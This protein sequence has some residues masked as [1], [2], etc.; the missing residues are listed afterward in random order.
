MALAA[1]EIWANGNPPPI[2]IEDA[3]NKAGDDVGQGLLCNAPVNV[4]GLNWALH[5][6]SACLYGELNSVSDAAG[7]IYN[8]DNPVNISDAVCA[9]AEQKA[10]QIATQLAT[11]IATDIATQIACQTFS[12]R[13]SGGRVPLHGLQQNALSFTVPPD[14]MW[15]VN[16]DYNG[17][18]A[19]PVVDGNNPQNIFLDD[20]HNASSGGDSVT[21]AGGTTITIEQTS[22]V[23]GYVT[24]FAMRI[25]CAN[26]AAPVAAAD[27]T[28][29]DCANDFPVSITGWPADVTLSAN[30]TDVPLNVSFTDDGGGMGTLASTGAVQNGTLTITGTDPVGAT[31]TQNIG[32]NC[33]SG[34]G[35]GSTSFSAPNDMTFNNCT[36]AFP[37]SIT[38]WPSTATISANGTDTAL[39]FSFTD[40]GNGTGSLNFAGSFNNGTVILTGTDNGYSDSQN[41]VIDCSQPPTS[42]GCT[43]QNNF[44]ADAINL[45]ISGGFADPDGDALTYTATGL[46]FGLSLHPATGIIT[47]N[48]S[49]GVFNILV[50]A[51]DPH[52]LSANCGFTWTFQNSAPVANCSDLTNAS[53]NGAY[54]SMSSFFTDADFDVLTFSTSGMPPGLGYDS[55]VA[56]ISG[57][58]SAPGV[59]S[60]MITADDGQG[61]VENCTFNWTIT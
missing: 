58:P 50:T 45:D 36:G 11:Q 56:G 28:I 5:K 48:G 25:D 52:G 17:G 38:G 14:G 60:V 29:T 34:S 7:L 41:I 18:A 51:E 27:F 3:S 12:D 43:D 1:N 2:S 44:T 61:H 57:T 21:V 20:T 16:W 8:P 39:G 9:I 26:A 30:G 19:T 6:Y 53:G 10:T 4:D 47:G 42:S 22:N 33:G 35:G 37:I 31:S 13:V 59:Y 24:W 55:A 40:N 46:P 32:L 23:G 15:L 49:E 54:V